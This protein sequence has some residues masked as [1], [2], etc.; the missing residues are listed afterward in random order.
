MFKKTPQKFHLATW[1]VKRALITFSLKAPQKF[2]ESFL[3]EFL[4]LCVLCFLM[5]QNK[6]GKKYAWPRAKNTLLTFLRIVF[7]SSV[8]GQ[9]FASL[10]T[11]A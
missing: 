11:L 7:P 3:T 1:R 8:L 9:L 6:I 10:G 5:H 4:T 2:H